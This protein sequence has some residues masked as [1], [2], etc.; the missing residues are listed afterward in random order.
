LERATL[1]IHE[2]PELV[3]RRLEL[4]LR[5]LLRLPGV[6]HAFDQDVAF[7]DAELL[8]RLVVH[9]LAA[10]RG[11]GKRNEPGE[12]QPGEV[13]AMNHETPRTKFIAMLSQLA[14][15]ILASYVGN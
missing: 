11:G 13:G 3:E 14:P 6:A 4:F 1:D 5:L 8:H 15:E 2:I 10:G 9:P 7:L 12:D